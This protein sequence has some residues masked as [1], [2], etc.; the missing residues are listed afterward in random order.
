MTELRIE[1]IVISG[2][3]VGVEN[4]LPFFRDKKANILP[5]EADGNRHW[6]RVFGYIK[7]DPHVLPYLRAE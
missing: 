7:A 2:A 6:T 1:N 5:F 3:R 4:P